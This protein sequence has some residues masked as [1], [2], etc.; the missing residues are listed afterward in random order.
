MCLDILF[1]TK[2]LAFC[3]AQ[4][5]GWVCQGSWRL[6]LT[7]GTIFGIFLRSDLEVNGFGSRTSISLSGARALCVLLCPLCKLSKSSSR[8]F[9]ALSIFLVFIPNFYCI[10]GGKKKHNHEAIYFSVLAELRVNISWPWF[11]HQAKNLI[12]DSVHILLNPLYFPCLSCCSHGPQGPEAFS[13]IL[14]NIRK[15]KQIT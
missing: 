3:K 1:C 7:L 6:S 2:T 13:F 12:S 8:S 9:C 15:E 10:D 11:A 5:A 14:N 4:N